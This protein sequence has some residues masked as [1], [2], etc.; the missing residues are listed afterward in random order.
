ML[1]LIP[2]F[3]LLFTPLSAQIYA[4][5]KV[6]QGT[7][8]IGT[9]TVTLEYLKAPRTCAN[10]IGLA[11]GKRPWVDVTNSAVRTNKPYYDGLTFHRLIHNFVIQG[12]SPNG[13]G[14]DGP[15]YEILDE[16]EPSL[17]HS[18]Y[19]ISMAKGEFPN[20]GGSQFFITL[21]PTPEL[22][23]K[24]SVFGRVTSGTEIVGK[25]KNSANFP[26]DTT[27]NT[28]PNV[29]TYDTPL[30]PIT[31]ES[32]TVYG[33]SFAAF[34]VNLPSLRLPTVVPTKITPIRNSETKQFQLGFERTAKTTYV[35][36]HSTDLAN[37]SNSGNFISFDSNPAQ[38]IDYGIVNFPSFFS[39]V[40]VVNYQQI[41]DPPADLVSADKNTVRIYYPNGSKLDLALTPTFSVWNS[42]DASGT[43]LGGGF[44]SNVSWMDYSPSSGNYRTDN[45]EP[46]RFSVGQLSVNFDGAA[47]PEGLSSLK[48]WLS[49]HTPNSGWLEEITPPKGS[50][51]VAPRRL[52]FEILSN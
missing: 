46:F 23:D 31:I 52:A 49:F 9:F 22:N 24:H 25:F 18:E 8:Q 10:F 43:P 44:L 17:R 11:T 33:P 14:T 5:F 12:G 47:G 19:V 37:W 35:V 7:N 15:G 1:R 28:N 29:R 50:P 42:E 2:A 4:D 21:A 6:R 16:Y 27:V 13:Q 40:A 45:S 41:P 51:P 34:D 36:Q 26:T 48:T 3:A 39:N 30:T 20:T 32:V 38:K